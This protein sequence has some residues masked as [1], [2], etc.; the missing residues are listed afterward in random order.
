MKLSFCFIQ[1]RWCIFRCSRHS[2]F[3]WAQNYPTKVFFFPLYKIWWY[4]FRCCC[5]EFCFFTK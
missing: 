1:M 2:I 3:Y 4:I 5:C